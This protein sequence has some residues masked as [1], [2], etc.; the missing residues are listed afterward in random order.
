MFKIKWPK[1][2]V[3]NTEINTYMYIYRMYIKAPS[4]G[5]RREFNNGIY[6]QVWSHLRK[7]PGNIK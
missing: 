5:F 7:I 1:N 2:I 6:S 3:D 4:D